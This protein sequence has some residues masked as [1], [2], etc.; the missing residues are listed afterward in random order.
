MHPFGKIHLRIESSIYFINPIRPRYVIIDSN[1]LV[2]INVIELNKFV[3]PSH[4]DKQI[5]S[6]LRVHEMAKALNIHSQTIIDIARAIGLDNISSPQ[7]GLS[8]VNQKK[9]A[10][11]IKMRLS[12]KKYLFY[13]ETILQN[14]KGILFVYRSEDFHIVL[15]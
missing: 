7:S 4:Y 14:I 12:L 8:V 3:D 1:D 13:E 5:Y 11:Y 15:G 9:V 2:N 10:D 6:N